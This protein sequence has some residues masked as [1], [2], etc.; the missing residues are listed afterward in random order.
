MET[1]THNGLINL[2]LD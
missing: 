2:M 1:E